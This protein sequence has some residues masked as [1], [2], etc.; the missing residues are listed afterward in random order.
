MGRLTEFKLN[1]TT[2]IEMYGNNVVRQK[3]CKSKKEAEKVRTKWV[4]EFWN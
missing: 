3:Q 1:G 4:N 2:V